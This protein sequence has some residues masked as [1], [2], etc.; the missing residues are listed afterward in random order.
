MAL[1]GN[2][3]RRYQAYERALCERENPVFHNLLVEMSQLHLCELEGELRLYFLACY[4]WLDAHGYRWDFS[5]SQR[6]VDFIGDQFDDGASPA[7]AAASL[8][9]SWR[10]FAVVG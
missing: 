7:Y 6:D 3:S 2:Q 5:G 9:R 8:A 4:N 1:G 10:R